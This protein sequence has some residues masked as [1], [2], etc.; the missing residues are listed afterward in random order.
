MIYISVQVV[1]N[2]AKYFAVKLYNSMKVRFVIWPGACKNFHESTMSECGSCILNLRKVTL[3]LPKANYVGSDRDQRA[4]ISRWNYIF[5]PE[6]SDCLQQLI[7]NNKNTLN[8]NTLNKNTLNKNAL[9]KNTL[10]KNSLNKNA[11]NK[12][13]LNKNTLKRTHWTQQ[14]VCCRNVYT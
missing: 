8:K 7:A 5:K 12:N 6:R 4:F 11:L 1:K 14:L 9:N 3:S 13:T 10:N 2:R